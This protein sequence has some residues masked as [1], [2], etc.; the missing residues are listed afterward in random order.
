MSQ[1]QACDHPTRYVN[2]KIDHRVAPPKWEKQVEWVVEEEEE[3]SDTEV[4]YNN[5]FD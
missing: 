2:Y 5:S 1:T 4:G 3:E